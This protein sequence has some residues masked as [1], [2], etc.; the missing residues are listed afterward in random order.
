MSPKQ[1]SLEHEICDN[2]T[3][4][5]RYTGSLD[6]QSQ[7]PHG[8]GRIDCPSQIYQGQWVD[9]DWSGYGTLTN[10]HTGDIY[11]GGFLDNKRHGQ[12][13]LQFADGR[14]YSGEFQLDVMR[15]GTMKYLDG[16][17]FWGYFDSDCVP[18][19]RGKYTYVDGSIYDGEFAHGIIEGHGRMTHNDGGWYL[20]EWCNGSKTGLEVFH[21]LLHE[22]D[23]M[24]R[25]PYIARYRF[26]K[27]VGTQDI[28]KEL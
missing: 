25:A 28:L 15:K 16:S 23:K 19:G 11:Q 12:G 13:V 17:T 20:G 6:K 3:Y 22:P 9:G 27:N 1:R 21:N 18:H 4:A 7:K 2:M 8:E 14:I 10:K 26:R 24:F 5:I